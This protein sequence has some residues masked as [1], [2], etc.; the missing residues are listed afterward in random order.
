MKYRKEDF[1]YVILDWHERLNERPWVRVF[2]SLSDAYENFLTG[3][4]D[5][6]FVAVESGYGDQL[7]INSVNLNE[8]YLALEANDSEDW[9]FG[10]PDE[11]IYLRDGEI[12]A[13]EQ[14]IKDNIIEDD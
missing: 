8:N 13:V 12:E 5:T 11:A 3:N 2:D 1:V 6:T 4:F 9:K 14:W 7:Q 10:I